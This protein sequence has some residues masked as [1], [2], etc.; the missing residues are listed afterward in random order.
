VQ[1][2]AGVD[3]RARALQGQPDGA[4]APRGMLVKHARLHR[5]QCP[6]AVRA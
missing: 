4:A 3:A 6:E 2:G 5:A 1:V